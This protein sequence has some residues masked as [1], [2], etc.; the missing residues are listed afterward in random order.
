MRRFMMAT[1]I[2]ALS[3]SAISAQ[4]I[5]DVPMP[6]RRPATPAIPVAPPDNCLERLK[7][8][9]I[10]T[11]APG[12]AAAQLDPACEIV[13]PVILLSV[14]DPKVPGRSIMFGDR[15]RVSCA[16]AERFA[17][18]TSEIAASLARGTLERE[19]V[20]LSTGPGHECRPRNR[21]PGAKLSS[22]GQGNAL[23]ISWM[24]LSGG[25]KVIVQH[26][27]DAAA[28]RFI[29]GFRAAACGVFSTV[30]GPGSDAAHDDHIHVDIEMRGRDGRSKMCQ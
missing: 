15:P 8:R 25:Y 24:E 10:A 22:H 23:D 13:E 2:F 21:Q 11:V 19:L 1:V 9:G 17:T 5:A 7:R 14:A 27:A 20:A 12:S 6:P 26:P 30:L 16:M 29:A 3:S 18:F 28:E 4:P